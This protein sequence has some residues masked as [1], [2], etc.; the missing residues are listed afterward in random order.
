MA[1]GW[2]LWEWMTDG[3]YAEVKRV[4]GVV[5]AGKWDH[6]ISQVDNLIWTAVAIGVYVLGNQLDI[7][8]IYAISGAAL[9]KIKGENGSKNG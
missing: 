1:D 3:N 6:V 4:T 2:Y 7:P 9:V 5:M 8:E